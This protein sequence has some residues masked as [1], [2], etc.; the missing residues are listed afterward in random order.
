MLNIYCD[1]SCHLENDNI[2][3]M[4]LGA[5]A[6]PDFA[7]ETVYNDVRNLRKSMGIP[8]HREIK[9]TKVSKAELHYYKK[10]I[11]FIYDNELLKFRAVLLPDKSIL[12]HDYY[13]RTHDDFYYVMYYYLLRKYMNYDE[14]VNVYIDIKDTRS[15]E[16]VEKLREIL[17]YY[18]QKNNSQEVEKIQQIRSHENVILQLADL[19]I[20]AIAYKNR[21]LNS[22]AAKLELIAYIE[23]K[24]KTSLTKTSRFSSEKFNLFVLDQL[25]EKV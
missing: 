10:L 11:D 6:V 12:N 21:G 22:S 23:S 16:K 3:I 9:W 8:T 14:R 20:G 25:K 18:A 5:L 19:L 4:M 7:K 13:G 15:K 1:E 24:F 17:N 2:K